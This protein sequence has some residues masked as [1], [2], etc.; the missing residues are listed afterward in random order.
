MLYSKTPSGW[1]IFK[2]VK[3]LEVWTTDTRFQAYVGVSLAFPSGSIR[4]S[5]N[6]RRFK[7]TLE[8]E[9]WTYMNSFI[10]C[11]FHAHPGY[12]ESDCNI[13]QISHLLS[14]VW[15]CCGAINFVQDLL[16]AVRTSCSSQLQ[17]MITSEIA[18]RRWCQMR[19]VHM[20]LQNWGTST[21]PPNHPI[22]FLAVSTQPLFLSD[23]MRV[24][25]IPRKKWIALLSPK[26]RHFPESSC[27]QTKISEET[28]GKY[29]VTSVFVLG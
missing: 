20:L 19:Y 5:K 29:S 24:C 26:V 4:V 27:S 18:Q 14:W 25:D 12:S 6:C 22:H 2:P 1:S 16:P 11:L 3:T 9:K 23:S 10:K 7:K 13:I 17:A 21:K 8:Q 15:S 28:K